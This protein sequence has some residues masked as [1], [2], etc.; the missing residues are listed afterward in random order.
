MVYLIVNAVFSA[1]RSLEHFW[2]GIL[3]PVG[4]QMI[5]VHR[6]LLDRRGKEHAALLLVATRQ[7]G[8]LSLQPPALDRRSASSRWRSRY[9]F[10]PMSVEALTAGRQGRRAAKAKQQE[11]A[12][13]T[14]APFA[15]RRRSCRSVQQYF[16][17][18]AGFDAIRLADARCASPTSSASCPS[19]RSRSC[20]P[21]SPSSTA[22]SPAKCT[23][24]M[25]TRSPS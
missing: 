5:D 17:G 18:S 16:G 1:T 7:P 8:R 12:E 14:P 4:L 24:Q 3:D 19:G 21:S 10:F 13:G 2:S 9:R 15:G 11:A 22:T 20:W 6:A 25:S 23:T